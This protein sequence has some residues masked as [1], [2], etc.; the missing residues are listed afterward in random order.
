MHSFGL[1]LFRR[2]VAS[3]FLCVSLLLSHAGSAEAAKCQFY[4]IAH[5]VNDIEL[6][7]YALSRGA[8]T[9]EIDIICRNGE[10]YV[11]HDFLEGYG[12]PLGEFLRRLW[13]V[14]RQNR[15]LAL[16]ILD[17]KD[18]CAPHGDANQALLSRT[19]MR[20]ARKTLRAE[21]VRVLYSVAKKESAPS[22]VNMVKGAGA[23]PIKG[24]VAFA[25]DQ[26]D[27]YRQVAK[28]L[29]ASH[30]MPF[31]YGNGIFVANPLF[32]LNY[33]IEESVAKAAAAPRGMRPRL[34]YIWTIRSSATMS[35]ML[36][37]G[38]DGIFVNPQSIPK[39]VGVMQESGKYRL[40]TRRGNPFQNRSVSRLRSVDL[41]A[42]TRLPKLMAT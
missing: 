4:A 1:R 24:G 19:I 8:N 40:P 31:A 20:E 9:I 13:H 3:L 27:D 7:K 22:L 28:E 21:G 6:V 23:H 12:N 33:A 11:A 30:P 37:A 29:Q 41:R 16:V 32:F 34:V 38:V 39:L 10:F 5:R 15:Q 2:F 14:A 25:I 35:R 42:R 18:V 26:E 17:I 36:A